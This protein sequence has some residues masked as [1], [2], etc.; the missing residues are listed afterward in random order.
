MKLG[1]LHLDNPF[2]QAPMSGVTDSPFRTIARKFHDGLLFTEM[3]SAEALR[4]GNLKTIKFLHGLKTQKPVV[5]QLAG[6]YPES[7]AEA[8]IIAQ[9]AGADFID[10]N[11]GCPQL[12]IT[13]PGSGAA[14]LKK[15]EKLEKIIEAVISNVSIPVSVKLRLGWNKDSSE[16]ICQLVQDAGAAFLKEGFKA[17]IERLLDQGVAVGN[18]K[19]ATGLVGTHKDVDQRHRGASLAGAGGHGQERLSPSTFER[20][21]DATDGFDLVGTASNVGIGRDPGKR[22]GVLAQVAQVVEVLTGKETID[23][24]RRSVARLPTVS[25]LAE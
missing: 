9:E 16:E 10:I 2:V 24:A 1:K 20:F 7:M 23:L 18:K 11:A 22:A 25:S 5:A 19:D 4:R 21:A 17:V 6:H 13:R 14:L 8:A 3:M 15:P 12:K